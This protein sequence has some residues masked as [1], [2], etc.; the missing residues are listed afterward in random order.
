MRKTRER[1]GR[2]AETG[3]LC[4][5]AHHPR[6]H[7][8]P[9]FGWEVKRKRAKKT[10]PTGSPSPAGRG[11]GVA[12]RRNNVLRESSILAADFYDIIRL[13]FTTAS[14]STPPYLDVLLFKYTYDLGCLFFVPRS[15]VGN[16][17][18]VCLVGPEFTYEYSTRHSD[19][20]STR[21]AS[22]TYDIGMLLLIYMVDLKSS[23]RGR[24]R[25]WTLN[26]RIA[27]AAAVCR[28]LQSSQVVAKQARPELCTCETP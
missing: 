22:T 27:A 1:E 28:S 20:N 2:E 3:T 11:M 6:P 13:I 24:K 5:A 23:L 8:P 10:P 21:H 26:R 12:V 7:T 4:P 14:G 25:W 19:I 9:V 18:Q 15:C 16:S 17:G